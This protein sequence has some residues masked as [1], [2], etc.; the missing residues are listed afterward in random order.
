VPFTRDG[1]AP[2]D[3]WDDA[4]DRHCEDN[5]MGIAGAAP[6]GV[7]A[8]APFVSELARAWQRDLPEHTE[9]QLTGTLVFADI[10]GFTSL[11][12][13]L[14]ARGRFG[15]EEMSDHLERVLSELLTAA[16]DRGGW[17]VKWGGDALLLMFDSGDHVLAACA[18]AGAMQARMRGA[19]V[20][21]ASVGR[22]RL[23]ISIGIHTGEFAF[24]LLGHRHRELLIAGDAAT[25]TAALEAAA[26]AGET[27]V[28]PEVAARLPSRCRGG[29]KG[30]GVILAAAPPDAAVL[31]P[32]PDAPGE[33]AGLL[34]ELV[35]DH[36]LS[37]G[38]SGEHRQVA[39]AFLEYS[40]MSEL[41]RTGGPKA[42]DDGLRRFVE[43]TQEACHRHLVSFHETD[44]SSDGGKVMLVAGAPRGVEDAAEAMLCAVRQVVDDPGPLSVRAG[45]TAGRAFTGAVGPPRR[46][47]YSVKGDV[48]NLA[49][50]VMGKAP[51]GEIWALPVV[52]EASRTRFV[53]DEVP[54]FLV[55]GKKAPV[56]VWS[57][58]AVL[59]RSE[60]HAD[61]P[62]IGRVHEMSVLTAALE[63]ARDG[64]GQYVELDGAAGIGKTRLLTELVDGAADMIVLRAAAE[65]YRGSTPY[66]LLRS[67]LL[68]A[69]GLLDVPIT[70]VMTGIESWR[71]I[72]GTPL[73]SWLPLLAPVFGVAMPD[74]A[75]TRDLAPRF[76]VDRLHALVLDLLRVALP[77]PALLV[78]DD[79]QFADEAS[80]EVLRYIAH[81]VADCPWAVVLAGRADPAERH[82]LELRA[83]RMTVGPISDDE[84]G[85]LVTADTDDSPL[86]P[87]VAT[88]VIVRSGG[89]PSFLRQ[90]AITAL[91]VADTDELPDTIESVVAARIDRLPPVQREVLRTAAVAGMS[92]DRY[93]LAELLG[94]STGWAKEVADLDEFLAAYGDELRFRQAVIRD[95]AYDGLA[96]RRRAA[97]HGRLATLLAARHPAADIAGVLSVHYLHAG[98][99]EKALAS[100]VTAADRAAEAY[101]NTEAAELYTRA[102]VAAGR[103]PQVA[104]ADRARLLER[105]G[106]VQVLLGEYASSDRTYT[107]AARLRR[108]DAASVA[109]IGLKKARSADRRGAYDLTLGRLRRVDEV[110]AG[111]PGPEAEDLRVEAAMRTGFTRFRQGRLPAARASCAAV[112]DRADEGRTPE[113]LAD[114]LA[115]LDIIDMNL[116][117]GGGHEGRA[118]RALSLHQRRGDLAGQARVHTQIGYRA[119]LD[120]RWDDAV[121]S[122]TKARDLVERQGDLPNVALA[123]A[124]LAEIFLDQGRLAAAEGALRAAIQV[125]RASESDNDVAF[126]RALLGRVLA[127]RGR[128]EESD[129]LLAQARA[130]FVVQGAKTE[131]VDADAYTAESLL[132][133]GRAIEA[134]TLAEHAMSSANRLSEQPAQGPLLNRV[135]GGCLDALGRPD[136]ADAAFDRSLETARRRGAD[137]EVAFTVAA[138]AA[139]ACAGRP[140]VDPSLVAEAVPLQRRLGLVVDLVAAESGGARPATEEEL[141]RGA[142]RS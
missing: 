116:G 79:M 95:T 139:R 55:K 46:R 65:P 34:P 74:S 120:G 67:L 32:V 1:A 56:L 92:I 66:S 11:T 91:T 22:V 36:L 52:V 18:A 115:L 98:D 57:V 62:L 85:V 141:V 119:Y 136:E 69:F 108:G 105:L 87:H 37:G 81:H 40:G 135:I 63:R 53:L 64:A 107:T 140:P 117:G 88:A 72:A 96:Y 131:V 86:A 2:G 19:G 8:L 134:L 102:I 5:D 68:C 7:D 128:Y 123:E 130:R 101:A 99:N 15:A 30:P 71:G 27:L 113:T 100:S 90:L 84:A 126:G 111:V 59:S 41:L 94:E 3:P 50:R 21:D 12:E 80:E 127:R 97:L 13:R 110:L 121:V 31:A 103:L 109:R 48:V 75:Q 58:G 129:A 6:S 35:R 76:R 77:T 38:G 51:P 73:V 61:L 20:L 89:N 47:S 29:R 114:A 82:G 4:P 122:Y 44:I 137:H 132:L 28:S 106:D 54:R 33:P 39:V 25:T 124:N 118:R 26:E 42:V 70:E 112:V 43:V 24:Y 60:I 104:A 142:V 23:R 49:A 10:S 16:Y 125:W 14:A 138:M 17:L 93:L 78:V 83:H 133:Q 45:I 9:R